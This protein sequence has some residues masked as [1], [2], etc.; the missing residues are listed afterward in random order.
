M[1]DDSIRIWR[2]LADVKV[3]HHFMEM[4]V[5]TIAKQIYDNARDLAETKKLAAEHK[6]LIR[7]EYSP[8]S[9]IEKFYFKDGSILKITLKMAIPL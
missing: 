1:A 9:G 4:N 7:F 8:T 2:E 5:I 3:G 6:E